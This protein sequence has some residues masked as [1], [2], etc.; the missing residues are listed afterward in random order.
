MCGFSVPKVGVYTTG[1][2]IKMLESDSN[3]FSPN[4]FISFNSLSLSFSRD[5]IS[6]ILTCNSVRKEK[7][8]TLAANNLVFNTTVNTTVVERELKQPPAGFLI[9]ENYFDFEFLMM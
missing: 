8:N 7:R 4:Y 3:L 1:V 2:E 6:H 9:F 5:V